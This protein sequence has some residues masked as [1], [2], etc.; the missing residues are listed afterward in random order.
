[1]PDL[2]P[3]VQRR[4]VSGFPPKSVFSPFQSR[5]AI[6]PDLDFLQPW[7]DHLPNRHS[8]L[9]PFQLQVPASVYHRYRVFMH[10]GVCQ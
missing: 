7:S 9:F 8:I 2:W 6:T 1:M 10:Y 4:W 3:E 5:Q